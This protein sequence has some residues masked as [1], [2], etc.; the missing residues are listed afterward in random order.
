MLASAT[1]Q[2]GRLEVGEK[3]RRGLTA[4]F[5]A[6]RLPWLR[7]PLRDLDKGPTA[8]SSQPPSAVCA[9][10]ER[11]HP[12]LS[13]QT[14]KPFSASPPSSALTVGPSPRCRCH[15]HLLTVRIMG[16]SPPGHPH[17]SLGLH[18]SFSLAPCLQGPL[19]PIHVAL[20][21]APARVAFSF[22]ALL[23]YTNRNCLYLRYTA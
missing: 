19:V 5:R 4:C 6:A 3:A 2:E 21:H 9:G 11:H 10:E 20:S 22:L 12:H 14:G 17:R 23:R 18:T 15:R 7:C 13:A 1:D 8:W 16:P